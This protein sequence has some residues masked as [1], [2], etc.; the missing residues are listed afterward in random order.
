MDNDCHC[1]ERQRRSHLLAVL[2]LLLCSVT[3]HAT[4]ITNDRAFDVAWQAYVPTLH[5]H[6]IRHLDLDDHTL[7]QLATHPGT[8]VQLRLRLDRYGR[9]QTVNVVQPSTVKP[10]TRACVHAARTMGRL[11]SLPRTIHDH[12]RRKGLLFTFATH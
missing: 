11:P 5:T 9:V 3:T 4:N 1:A 2:Y 7:H 12:G 8:G 6:F 10:F